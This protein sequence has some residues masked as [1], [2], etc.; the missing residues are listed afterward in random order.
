VVLGVMWFLNR[1]GSSRR[2][3]HDAVPYPSAAPTSYDMDLTPPPG[4]AAASYA[5]PM[6]PR[7]PR[8][9][10]PVL[11]W[12]T[13]ALI[14]LAEGVLG[15]VDV[16]GVDV[17]PSAYPAL[18]L[19]IIAAMLLLGAFWGRAGGLI[20]L[21][22]VVALATVVTS[23]ASSWEEQRIRHSPTEAAEVRG[24]YELEE[25][26]LVLDLS[27]IDDVEELDGRTIHV[28]GGVGRIE[29]IVPDGVDVQ[30]TTDVGV[31]E[32]SLFRQRSGGLGTTLEGSLDGGSDVPD[33]DITIDLG[34]G[35]VVVREN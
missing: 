11:F 25:G 26:D 7:K 22:A 28:D 23:A 3:D 20:L 8:K 15:V 21:G 34:V 12:F 33:V 32:A 1:K 30:V 16:A 4:A 13:L 14:A 10:G 9:R 18:A 35:E 27:G 29:V 17:L 5:R 31:G 6:P 2:Q 24:S 19:G